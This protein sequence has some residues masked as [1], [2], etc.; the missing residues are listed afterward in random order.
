MGEPTPMSR[1]QVRTSFVGIHFW[2]DAPDEVAFLRHPH[3]HV[4][5]ISA[6]C[7]VTHEDR[8]LEFFMVRQQ[9]DNWVCSLPP[10]HPNMNDIKQLGHWSCEHMAEEI[11]SRLQIKYS[12]NF[13]VIVRE[14]DENAGIV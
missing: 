13:S 11:R 1:I 6:M 12:R 8:E 14:D 10:Y 5:K 7:E 2:A 4:F 9:I 3:R